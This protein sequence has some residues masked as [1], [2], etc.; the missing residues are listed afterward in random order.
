MVEVVPAWYQI[1]ERAEAD[2]RQLIQQALVDGRYGEVVKL[3]RLADGIS[4]LVAENRAGEVD[5]EPVGS[6]ATFAS[7][8][9]KQLSSPASETAPHSALA[10]VQRRA[11]SRTFP[12]FEREADKLVK[13]AWSKKDRAEYEH[14][15]PRW[16]IDVLLDAIRARKGEGAR[17]EAPDIFP[18]KDPQTGR[19]I[20]SYQSYLALAWLR[21]EGVVVKYGRDGYSLKPTAA[22]K[23]HLA[24]LWEALPFRG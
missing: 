23:E 12:R 11:R 16:V 10:S 2:L 15:A 22:T 14:K 6:Q 13:I 18:L 21:H 9:A 19:E 24:E 8:Q 17:F 20:P 3:A 7:S 1:L 5:V 4:R